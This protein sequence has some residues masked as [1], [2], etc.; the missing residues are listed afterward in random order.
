MAIY[1]YACRDCKGVFDVSRSIHEEA[2]ETVTCPE[3]W[4]SDTVKTFSAPGLVFKS[5]GFYTTDNRKDT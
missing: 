1:A 3:C 4:S 2:P 5:K